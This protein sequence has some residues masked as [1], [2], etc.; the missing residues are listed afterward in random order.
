[1][2]KNPEI[3][4]QSKNRTAVLAIAVLGTLLMSVGLASTLFASA[5]SGDE[6]R[7][8]Q[9]MGPMEEIPEE[10]DTDG[11]G[12]ISEEERQAYHDAM[13]QEKW[14]AIDTNGDGLISEE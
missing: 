11:D 12:E 8:I 3:Q 7:P 10:A 2:T 1:M 9:P 13:R 5:E 6:D 4:K 14:D